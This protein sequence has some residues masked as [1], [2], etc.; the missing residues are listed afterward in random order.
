[1]DAQMTIRLPA[2]LSSKVK[3]KAKRLGLK[4][5]DIIRRALT[6]YLEGPDEDTPL[7]DRVKHLVGSV[8]SGIPDLGLNHRKYLIQKLTQN[9]KTRG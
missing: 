5:S 3:E 8:K 7:Y 4:R 1:M 9:H 6:E 2:D